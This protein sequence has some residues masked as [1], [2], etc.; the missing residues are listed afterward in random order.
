MNAQVFV[1]C[2]AALI[3]QGAH[4]QDPDTAGDGKTQSGY[5]DL[6]EFGGPESV[7][8]ELKR[9]D[10]D[11]D[12]IYQFDSLQR[13]LAPYFDW[14]RR[15][16]DENGFAM[17]FQF[18]ALYQQASSSLDGEDDDALG[19]IFRFQGNWTLFRKDNG[20]LGRIEYRVESRSNMGGFQAPGSLASA[21]GIST[22]APGFGY[23]DSFDL[24][25][26]VINWTQGFAGGKVGICGR[27]PGIRRLSRCIPVSDLFEGLY[28]SLLHT[29]SPRCRQPALVRSAA[30]RQ[31]LRL[32][33]C[34]AGC[35]NSRCQRR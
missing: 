2:F 16:H 22:L 9:N 26:P 24:D 5:E 30:C 34:L 25:I 29:E 21:A 11:R 13:N 3:M 7:T 35:P 33:Q 32:G 4:G 1:I 23:S 20:N 14:K 17:G 19:N 6:A 8:S 31:R 18:Y 15:V 12:G 27:S 10:M 28:Q